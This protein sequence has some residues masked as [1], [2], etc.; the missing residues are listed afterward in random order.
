MWHENRK[1]QINW[2]RGRRIIWVLGPIS[3]C[4]D[5]SN[6]PI[7]WWWMAYDIQGQCAMLSDSKTGLGRTHTLMLL[8]EASYLNSSAS[9][10]LAPQEL[11]NWGSSH[12]TLASSFQ[13]HGVAMHPACKHI[14]VQIPQNLDFLLLFFFVHCWKC[15]LDIWDE[16][17]TSNMF[18]MQELK[19]FYANWTVFLWNFYYVLLLRS[20]RCH[21]YQWCRIVCAV[22]TCG[23]WDMRGNGVGRYTLRYLKFH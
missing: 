21:I 12:Q 6:R 4:K 1:L 23:V 19:Y 7:Y 17:C 10:L 8:K 18:G 11:R 13:W 22:F 9:G 5:N 20:V 14:V 15:S 16:Y 3:V 2:D